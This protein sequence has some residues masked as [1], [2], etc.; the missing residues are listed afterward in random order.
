MGP[1]L[2]DVLF[3]DFNPSGKLPITFPRN[4]GQVPLYY[5][6]KLTGRPPS[7]TDH[8]TS[9]YLDVPWTPLYP[10]GHGLSYTHFHYG[11]LQLSATKLPAQGN[12]SVRISVKNAGQRAGTEVVQL[13]L[14]DN[15][16][17]TTRPV[18]QLRG[19]QRVQLQPG[20]S[21]DLTFALDQDDFALFAD[22]KGRERVVEAGTFT[23]M[24]GG[25]AEAVQSA[26]FEVTSSSKLPALGP[27]IPRELRTET[28]K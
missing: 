23:V 19:Y 2:A 12:L 27:A 10:F 13:Y 22:S 26:T 4:I 24:V 1:G 11:A 7:L 28:K 20:E 6:Q 8:Y 21:R 3:G 16:G 25:S 18:K 9:R 15:V 17:S 14:R 5:A